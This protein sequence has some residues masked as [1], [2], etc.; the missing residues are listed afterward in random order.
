MRILMLAPGAWIHS[1]RS[2]NCLLENGQEVTL[3]DINNPFP[4]GRR[5]YKFIRY[6]R[7]GERYYR[8]FVGSRISDQLSLRLTVSQL[9]MLWR[10]LKP[11]V[12][13]VCW[14]DL[15][16]YHCI[17]AGLKPLVVS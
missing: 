13:H 8:R 5:G 12:V 2:V 1:E 14:L 16:A 17:E 7:T 6:P 10:R 9:K 3:V 4:E 15:R 11:D